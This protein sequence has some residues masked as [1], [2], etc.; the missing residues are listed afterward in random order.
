MRYSY[1]P[2][3]DC[4]LICVSA[5][6]IF[7]G[8]PDEDVTPLLQGID[9]HATNAYHE[10]DGDHDLDQHMALLAAG[11]LAGAALQWHV[12]QPRDITISWRELRRALAN[13]YIPE[14]RAITAATQSPHRRVGIID[15]VEDTG[16]VAGHLSSFCTTYSLTPWASGSVGLTRETSRALHVVLPQGLYNGQLEIKVSMFV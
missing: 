7:R 10:Y 3:A 13:H 8:E 14:A 6:P 16:H 9:R 2:W 4:W 11:H 1:D 12:H 15:V 5:I